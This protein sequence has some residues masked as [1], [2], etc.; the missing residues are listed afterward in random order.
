MLLSKY[1]PVCL[2]S[3]ERCGHNLRNDYAN[4]RGISIAGQTA[5]IDKMF[6]LASLIFHPYGRHRRRRE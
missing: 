6:E 3:I 5:P 2:I 4:M 1:A